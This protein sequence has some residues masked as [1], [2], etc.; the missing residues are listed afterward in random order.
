MTETILKAEHLTK[1]FSTEKGSFPAVRD[2][3]FAVKK[4]EAL[5]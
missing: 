3:S 5:G 4:G 2:I 1:I